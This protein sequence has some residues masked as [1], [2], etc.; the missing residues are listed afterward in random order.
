VRQQL[1]IR[2]RDYNWKLLFS[3]GNDGT[4]LNTFYNRVAEHNYTLIFI[5]E[6]SG[7]VFGGFCTESWQPLNKYFGTGESFVISVRPKVD[8][9]KWTTSNDYF[10]FASMEYLAMGGGGVGG[11][12]AFYLDADFSWGTSEVSQTYLNRRLS[13]A[14]EFSCVLVEVW[15]LVGSKNQPI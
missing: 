15:G 3:T 13:S 8:C 6:S 5:K 14:E 1:P 7:N 11:R 9:Y 4:S 10:M 2:L 12:H